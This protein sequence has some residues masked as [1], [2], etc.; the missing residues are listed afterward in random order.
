MN[1]LCLLTSVPTM[2]AIIG[3]KIQLDLATAE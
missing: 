2:T 1:K 3:R